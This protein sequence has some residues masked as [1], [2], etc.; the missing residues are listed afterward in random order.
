MKSRKQKEKGAKRKQFQ[1]MIEKSKKSQ[2]FD[3]D[4]KENENKYS[5]P[6][7]RIQKIKKNKKN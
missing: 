3:F 6:K 2:K 1:Q 4:M 7:K 5:G